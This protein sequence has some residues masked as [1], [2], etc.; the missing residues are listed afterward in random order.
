MGMIINID[1]ALELRTDY[2]VCKEPLNKML[3]DSQEA[4][5]KQNPIDLLFVRGSI[6]S[7]QE[8]YT[9]SIGFD[10]AFVETSDLGVGPIFNTAE[11]FSATYRTRTFQ[12]SFIISLQTLEDGRIGQVKEDAKRF[13][14]RWH[15]DIVDYAMKAIASGFG[16]EVTFGSGANLSKLKLTSCDTT[17]GTINGV[18]NPLFSKAHTIV[19]RDGMTTAQIN[20]AKQSNLFYGGVDLSGS[21]S[22]KISKLADV[23]NQVI[24]VMENYKDDNGKRASVVGSKKIVAGNDAH[25]KAALNTA[26]SLE[27]FNGVGQGNILNPAYKRAEVVTTPYLLDIDQCSSGKGFFI[28]DEAYNASNHGPELTERVPFTLD[29]ENMSRPKAI[30]YDGR[31]RFDINSSSW[32]GIVYV[33]VGTPAGDSGEWDYVSNFTQITPDSTIVTPVS[34]SGQ[35][36]EIN[37]VTPPAETPVAP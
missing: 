1:K 8:T 22:A 7:F 20:A 10:K 11:G 4:W 17:D 5:D 37:D 30:A 13:Q 28:V 16:Y 12:G 25:L 27:M 6:K 36:I 24:T 9:S 3:M 26:L 2:N 29:V 15:A 14:E 33:Y 18:K 34:I 32:R 21:D 19:K 23:I 35:P 31:Q